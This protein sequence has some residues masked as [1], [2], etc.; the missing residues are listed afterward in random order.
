MQARSS[1]SVRSAMKTYDASCSSLLL[2]LRRHR[3]GEFLR[4]GV[5]E[6]NQDAFQALV[7]GGGLWGQRLGVQRRF[8]PRVGG[9]VVELAAAVELVPLRGRELAR[10]I[11]DPLIW[12]V[13]RVDPLARIAF[14][15][16]KLRVEAAPVDLQLGRNGRAGGVTKGW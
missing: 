2:L 11:D 10:C 6:V 1:A 15:P 5:L 8:L 4:A 16:T 13:P 3:L 14:P 9:V 7:H 12:G